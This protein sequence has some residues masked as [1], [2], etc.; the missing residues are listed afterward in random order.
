MSKSVLKE[1]ANWVEKGVITEGVAESIRIYY[2][3]SENKNSNRLTTAFGI[4]GALLVGLGLLLLVAHNWDEFPRGIKLGFAFLPLVLTQ[5][6]AFVLVQRDVASA[7]WREGCAT[8]LVLSIGVSI[9]LV[10]QVY[11]ISGDLAKFLLVWMTLSLPVIYLLRSSMACL[12]YFAGVT[13]FGALGY[14]EPLRTA[15]FFIKYGLLMTAGLPW[16]FRLIRTK[17]GATFTCLHH[18]LIAGSAAIVLGTCSYQNSAWVLPAY[19]SLFGVLII[20]GQSNELSNTRLIGNGF[21]IGGTIGTL[22]LLFFLTFE[23]YW[24]LTERFI[25]ALVLSREFFAWGSLTGIALFLSVRQLRHRHISEWNVLNLTFLAMVP[26][27]LT[28]FHSPGTARALINTLIFCVAVITIWQGAASDQL[29][30]MN[31]GLLI[32]AVLVTCRFFDTEL[33]FLL[34]GTIFILVGTGFFFAN[35]QMVKKRKERR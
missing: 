35:Y 27:V 1:V 3:E 33:S 31:G 21:L 15:P 2:R 28:G 4:L 29:G 14:D 16:Y 18:W 7:G 24:Q 30:R 5:T 12:L 6:V 19:I 13:W 34:R 23:I 9:S 17:P 32:L 10:S 20:L 22:L 8:L 26:I 11:N 25:H